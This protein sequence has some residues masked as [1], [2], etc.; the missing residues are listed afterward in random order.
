MCQM[1]GR[2][3]I[4]TIGFGRTEVSSLSLV[5]YPPARITAFIVAAPW[6]PAPWHA[7][8][9][10]SASP[11]LVTPDRAARTGM[12]TLGRHRIRDDGTRFPDHRSVRDR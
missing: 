4:S 2:P 8:P 3:P 11:G 1:I 7:P 6:L 10:T 12:I 5:P 9:E